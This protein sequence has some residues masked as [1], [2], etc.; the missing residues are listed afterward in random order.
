MGDDSAVISYAAI[1]TRIY[2]IRGQKVILDRDLCSPVWH[3]CQSAQASRSAE[4]GA[5]SRRFHVHLE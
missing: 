4:H 5:I 1:E 3:S 2:F